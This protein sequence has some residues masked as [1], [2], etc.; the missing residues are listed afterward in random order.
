MNSTRFHCI[1]QPI[2]LVLIFNFNSILS[3]KSKKFHLLNIT[4]KMNDAISVKMKEI[5]ININGKCRSSLES[6]FIQCKMEL[7]YDFQSI[8]TSS[9][10]LQS[11]SLWPICCAINSYTECMEKGIQMNSFYSMMLCDENDVS[12]VQSII[13]SINQHKI[14]NGF[15]PNNQHMEYVLCNVE[16]NRFFGHNWFTKMV[17]ILGSVALILAFILAGFVLFS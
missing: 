10:A 3:E 13:Q 9:P 15:C 2:L 16:R 8:I 11:E 12:I 1:L 6:K 7:K 4:E 17:L 5:I 14:T